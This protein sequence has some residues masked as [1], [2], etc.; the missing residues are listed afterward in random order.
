MSNP[1]FERGLPKSLDR[2][3]FLPPDVAS[4]SVEDVARTLAFVTADAIIRAQDHLNAKPHLWI[5]CGGGRLNPYIM[6]DLSSIAEAHFA[7]VAT[8]EEFG[9]DGDAM[10]AE[11]WAYLAVRSLE[12]LPI[13]FPTTTGVNKPV[14]GGKLARA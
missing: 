1:Y 13:T 10:E 3:D 11:C 8:A 9:L 12:D 7:R 2:N 4:G 14:S 5:I 6:R